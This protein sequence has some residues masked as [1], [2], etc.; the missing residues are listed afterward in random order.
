MNYEILLKI[1]TLIILLI[2]SGLFSGAETA[3]SSLNIITVKKLKKK[4]V[5]EANTLEK[6]LSRPSKTLSTILIGNN[7][8]NI[9]ATAIATELTLSLFS[10]KQVTFIVTMIM[11]ILILI[12]GEI[13]PK[14]Y[15]AYNSEKVVI[16]L[17]K[18]LEVL[19]VVFTPF[20]IV[21][22]RVTKVI[23]KALG[24]NVNNNRTTVSEEEIKTLV[25]VGEEAGIIEK[26]E[27]EMIN[28]IFE[29]GDIEVTEVM[30][31]RIDIVYLEE[32]VTVEE[33]I[34]KV[35]K[36]G[37]S[38]IPVIKKSIDNI[39]GIIYAKDLLAC[40]FKQ[41]KDES[42]GIRELIRPAYYVPESKKAIDLLTEMQLEKIHIAIVLDEYGGTLGL[43]TIEDILEEIVGDILD[44]YDEEMDL[45]DYLDEQTLIVDSKISIDEIN[46]TFKISLPEDEF[47]SVGGLIFNLLGRIPKKGDNIEYNGL[48]FKILEVHNRRIKKVEISKI[49]HKGDTK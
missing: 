23:I 27:K 37:F 4:G 22:N 10:G 9:A 31:P 14:T 11:T 40:Y 18:P 45:I 1:I 20:L 49:N 39:T 28:S 6:L 13:T 21:L 29:I 15:S 33:A 24:G 2:F 35:L 19:S 36:C 26:Q 16:K 48:L 41:D 42:K 47:E 32:D 30:V 3:L 46:E 38:R 25:D 34:K 43:V 7:I 44:E 5:K 8:V 17:G 12:F